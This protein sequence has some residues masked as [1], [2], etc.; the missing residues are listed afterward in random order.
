MMIWPAFASSH[1]RDARFVTAP[2]EDLTLKGFARPVPAVEILKWRHENDD[3]A[4][5]TAAAVGASATS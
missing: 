2:I 1:N 3:M 4:L 5:P